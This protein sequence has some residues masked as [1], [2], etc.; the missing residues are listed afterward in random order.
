VVLATKSSALNAGYFIFA[1]IFSTLHW[2]A[3]KA[4]PLPAGI[5]TKVL[6]VLRQPG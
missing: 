1:F 4:S 6:A 3:G 2:F 5:G